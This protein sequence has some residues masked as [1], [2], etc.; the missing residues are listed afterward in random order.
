MQAQIINVRRGDK[1]GKQWRVSS[2]VVQLEDGPEP[3]RL[4]LRDSD[5]DVRPGDKVELLPRFYPNRD[6]GLSVAFDIKALP[7]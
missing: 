1:N 7:K 3:I 2:M 6:G 4:F 5:P